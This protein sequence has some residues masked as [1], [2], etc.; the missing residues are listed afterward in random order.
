MKKKIFF[1]PIDEIVDFA[2]IASENL[3]KA[4]I[5]DSSFNEV[6][7]SVEYNPVKEK[8]AIIDLKTC[9]NKGYSID[10]KDE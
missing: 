8:L 9:L 6:V 1:V 5:F 2:E 10:E 4:V 7:F 3:L